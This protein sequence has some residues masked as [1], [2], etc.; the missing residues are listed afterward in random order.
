MRY[1]AR[2]GIAAGAAGLR[3][4][5]TFD[6]AEFD[7]RVRLRPAAAQ[8]TSAPLPVSA[9]VQ[10]IGRGSC[11]SRAVEQSAAA[12]DCGRGPARLISRVRGARWEEGR[13]ASAAARVRTRRQ[14]SGELGCA[15][16]RDCAVLSYVRDP[17][18]RTSAW[19]LLRKR[20]RG[21]R[22]RRVFGSA[23]RP[24]A[25]HEQYR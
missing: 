22:V 3:G 7:A 5:A 14:E 8:R 11:A 23:S 17:R 19:P 13:G 1:G 20:N 9:P 15:S 6:V 16:R 24:G 21:V 2:T 12:S 4:A 10:G 25:T 18:A